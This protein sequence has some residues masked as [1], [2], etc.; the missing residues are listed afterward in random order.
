MTFHRKLKACDGGTVTPDCR[1]FPD[2][3]LGDMSTEASSG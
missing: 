1:E 2:G 3:G